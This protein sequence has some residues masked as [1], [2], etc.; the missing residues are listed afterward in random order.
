MQETSLD[1]STNK[2]KLRSNQFKNA[3]K[4][5]K[6][7]SEA[8]ESWS[9]IDNRQFEIM[10]SNVDNSEK[11]IAFDD[12]LNEI[13]RIHPRAN[14][15]YCM[16]LQRQ[17]S[18]TDKKNVDKL[19]LIAKAAY[20][21]RRD[22]N[23]TLY[24]KIINDAYE[25]SSSKKTFPFK[26]AVEEYRDEVKNAEQREKIE[27]D[28]CKI[29]TYIEEGKLPPEKKLQLIDEAV[30]M[31]NEPYFKKSK[32][33]KEKA[34][35]CKWAVSICREELPYDTESLEYYKRQAFKYEKNADNAVRMGKKRRGL[36]TE[37]EE[38]E[39]RKKYGDANNKD[40]LLKN[41]KFGG[42]D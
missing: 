8:N 5:F 29:S 42:R 37:A 34:T 31:I 35:F 36:W 19:E 18:Y 21:H 9:L 41:G 25:M 38:L 16:A 3:C 7:G 12:V 20:F 13:I 1:I 23:I 14:T 28:L 33:N 24:G 15:A 39:Y 22:V 4:E 2:F 17:L 10:D 26:D 40:L 11:I 30:A 6:N 32:A 27:D